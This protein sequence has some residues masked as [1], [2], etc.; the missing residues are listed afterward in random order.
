MQFSCTKGDDIIQRVDGLDYSVQ[1][2][3]D[4]IPSSFLG[5][6]CSYIESRRTNFWPSDIT[7][8]GI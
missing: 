6:Y 8:K 7:Y 3:Y 4:S 2:F 1:D 5:T